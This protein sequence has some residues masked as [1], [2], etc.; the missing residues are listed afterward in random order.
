MV[1]QTRV[2]L[3][4]L[5]AGVVIILAPLPA[6]L[7]EAGRA[8]GVVGALMAL[9]WV[10]QALPL[11]VTALIPLAAF[12][13]VGVS[14]IENLSRAYA[15]P[16]VFMFMG[17]FFLAA[18]LQRWEL[19][20]HLSRIALDLVGSRPDLQVLSMMAATAFLSL[21][22]SNT[23]AT[24]VMMPIAMALIS[25]PVG[26]GRNA[27]EPVAMNAPQHQELHAMETG[28]FG[29]AMMLG[30]AYAATIGGMGSLIGTPPNALFASFVD[31]TYGIS[32][33]FGQWMLLGVPIV[34]TLLPITWLLLIRV[35]FQVPSKSILTGHQQEKP[36]AMSFAQRTIAAV[37]A[38][39]ALA[40]AFRP[41]LALWLDLPGLS[42]SGIAIAAA[43]ALFILPADKALSRPLLNWNDVRLIRWDILIL[44]GGGLALSNAIQTT[45]LSDWI[46]GGAAALSNLPVLALVI[47]IMFLMVFLGEL[48][49]NTAM[50][51][52]FLPIVA[53]V[54]AGIGAEPLML[55]LPVAL[56]ASIGFMLPI[57]TGPNALVLGS[58]AVS[59]KD[60][61]RAGAL[62]NVV[63]TLIVFFIATT[64][65]P[66]VFG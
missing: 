29:P 8:T 12:P 5:A 49:S 16:L 7:T 13:L 17:G 3:T 24:L 20:T 58:G 39:T 37:L 59:A 62:L 23:A 41:S 52:I 35:T 55:L 26:S 40:W 50:A 31:K 36:P 63:V 6:G 51:A 44:L 54:A 33:G 18:A 10:T 4:G 64:L 60:M 34:L 27:T 56:A 25:V 46:G 32:I 57:A 15:H 1:F 65:G 21:W 2:L 43:L 14:N 48:V 61:L 11:A 30:I 19:H 28:T 42:D 22:I 45:G 47:I 9:F 66:L 53:A 38:V